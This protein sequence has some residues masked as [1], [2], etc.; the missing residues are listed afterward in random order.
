MTTPD[1]TNQRP[2]P[3]QAGDL[4][5]PSYREP[6]SLR[7]QVA[8]T[9][10]AQL[11]SGQ[12]K[13]GVTYSAPRLA[14][15]FGVSATPVREAMLDLVSEG[16]VEVVRNKGFRVTHLSDADLDAMAELRALIEV[17]V[18]GMVAEKCTGPIAAAV[19]ELRPVAD[20]ITAAAARKDLVDYI[21]RD[22]EFHLRFLALHGNEHVVSVVRDLRSRS[23]LYGLETL[24]GTG[25]MLTLCHE[26]N[27][28]V[29]V[30][31]A[32]DASRMRAL[33]QQHISHVRSVWAGRDE[34]S[35]E[36]AAHP[37][38]LDGAEDR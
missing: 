29:D 21:E 2:V 7:G 12:M 27:E 24:L 35:D 19:E 33:M 15:Q 26:H 13:P 37:A 5:L 11:I 1:P 17:P 34:D 9:L 22:T 38:D 36:A 10:R 3:D 14:A 25:L 28:M 20:A 6:P 31:L 16:H 32:R 18:M 4:D 30:A 8:E 23:R